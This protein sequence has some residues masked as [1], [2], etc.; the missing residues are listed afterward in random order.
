MVRAGW[1]QTALLIQSGAPPTCI[2]LE[3][4]PNTTVGDVRVP[5]PRAEAA[6]VC[7]ERVQRGRTF[8][9]T[10]TRRG[11]RKIAMS[12]SSSHGEER[13]HPIIQQR[14]LRKRQAAVAVTPQGGRYAHAP[15]CV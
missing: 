10:P 9:M 3:E 14:H 4:G 13:N 15:T 6:S 7:T 1:P 11:Y 12:K 8:Q 5:E 2:F